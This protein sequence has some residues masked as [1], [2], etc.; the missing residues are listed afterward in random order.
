MLQRSTTHFQAKQENSLHKP[1]F[2]WNKKTD[3]IHKSSSSVY[4]VQIE[5]LSNDINA[6]VKL[7]AYFVLI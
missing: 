5:N 4:E 2:R 6:T 3:F 1:I 7:K